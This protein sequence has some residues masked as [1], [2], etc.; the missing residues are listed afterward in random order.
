MEANRFNVLLK[1]KELDL[2]ILI[3]M[4][5]ATIT[6]NVSIDVVKSGRVQLNIDSDIL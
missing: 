5:D 4:F 1:I 2:T 3:G 6:L